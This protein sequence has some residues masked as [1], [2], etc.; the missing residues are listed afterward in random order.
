[1]NV[2]IETERLLLRTFTLDDA[3]LIYDLNL[4]PDVTRYTLDPMA[5]I[6]KAKE[7]LEKTILP[8]Y[9]LYDHGRWAVHVR[10]GLEFIGWCGLKTRP[11]M[12]EIDLG[13]RFIKK[14]WGKGYAT[15]SA[16]ACIK[17]GFE[18]LGLKRIVGRSLPANAASIRVLEKCGMTY[19]GEEVIEGL[20]H[21]TYEAYNPFIH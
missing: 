15:E 7:V 10:P 11:E 20:L 5:D 14:V 8:Q 19:V 16:Y 9:A 3:P 12:N 4:D 17:Y 18:N 6:E 1:M 13:Y 21:K 2:V